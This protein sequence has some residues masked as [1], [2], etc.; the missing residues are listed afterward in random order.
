MSQKTI[1]PKKGIARR[2]HQFGGLQNHPDLLQDAEV[3][4][5]YGCNNG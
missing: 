5:T 2:P 4:Q 1:T 3:A